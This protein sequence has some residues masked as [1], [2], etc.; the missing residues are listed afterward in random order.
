MSESQ[1]T[2]TTFILLFCLPGDLTGVKPE[3]LCNTVANNWQKEQ[4]GK[5]TDAFELLILSPTGIER[6]DESPDEYS[7]F[8]G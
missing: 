5:N 4:N 2:V 3:Y 6:L 1:A 7:S 8:A